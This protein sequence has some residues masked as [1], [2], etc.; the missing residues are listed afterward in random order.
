MFDRG[1]W[2]SAVMLILVPLLAACG[3]NPTET[4]VLGEILKEETFDADFA[5]MNYF[6]ADQNVDFRV[7]NGVYRAQASDSGFMWT[8]DAD[9]HTNV[10]IQV[11]AQ[12]LSAFR[13]NAYGLMCRAST[14]DNGDG[15]Y[16]LIS[17]DGYYTIRVGATD[18]IRA[19]IPWTRSDAI[20]QDQSI[21][22]IR[23]VCVDDYL[24]LYL[25]GQFIAEARDT[26]FR[27]GYT[28]LVAGVPGQGDIDVQFDTL[29]IREASLSP[30]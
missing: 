19:L 27:R 23:I 26:R 17:G 24:A 1:F 13:N 18:Q 14:S 2:R 6:N 16:F 25:N 29:T 7:E 28:G 10:S 8:I 15:Y 21:N 12:Q 5:W 30:Q 11:D 22:R 9:V 20:Q 4:I 3:T